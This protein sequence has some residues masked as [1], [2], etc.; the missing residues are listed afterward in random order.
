MAIQSYRLMF[1]FWLDISKAD[2]ESV[3]DIIEKLKSARA[4]SAAI[5]DGLRLIWDLRQGKI[6]VLLELFPFVKAAIAERVGDSGNKGGV[7]K[8]DLERIELLI[9]L[10]LIALEHF[11]LHRL[12]DARMQL[13]EA[14]RKPDLG[15]VPWPRQVNLELADWP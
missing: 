6:D 9:L 10:L 15:H 1:K 8:A 2:E 14:R 4:F 11:F 13:D 3:A 5:R 12:P 7:S